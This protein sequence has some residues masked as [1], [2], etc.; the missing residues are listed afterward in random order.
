MVAGAAAERLQ[1]AFAAVAEGPMADVPILNPALHV[2][3]VGMQAW[4]GDWLAVLVTPWA[5]NFVLLPGEGTAFRVLEVG[6]SQ[7][8]RFPSGEYEFLGQCVDGLGAYQSCALFSPMAQFPDQAVAEDTAREC[9]AVLL[10]PDAN[11]AA[12]R[13]ERARLD[14]RPVLAEGVSRRGFLR[15]SWF[16]GGA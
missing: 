14:G 12:V 16:G 10:Q 11:V 3:V 15:G 4:E 13:A 5:M 9:L 8:W 2:S 6:Q 7:I 1:R